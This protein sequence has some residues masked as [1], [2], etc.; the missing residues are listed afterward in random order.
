[1]ADDPAIDL[2]SVVW[3]ES[4]P[5]IARFGQ[6]AE[7]A[8]AA[9]EE[10]RRGRAVL[11]RNDASAAVSLAA[12]QAL[13]NVVGGPP[14][15]LDEH[16]NIG[17]ARA[18]NRVFEAASAPYVALLDPDGAPEPEML[19]AL[20]AV[21]DAN[22]DAAT[23][24]A[25]VLDF[26]V[27]AETR[28]AVVEEQ[29]T[30]GGATMYRRHAF[31]EIGGFDPLFPWYCQDMDFGYRARKNGWRCLRVPAAVFRHPVSR[32]A[33]VRR[34]WR[35]TESLLAWRHVHFSRA[36]TAKSWLAQL[37]LAL[38]TAQPPRW[39]TA[40]GVILGLM[41]YVRLIPACERRRR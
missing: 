16:R 2:V 20:V 18:V 8:W 38:R 41:S 11:L 39:A 37:P 30:P 33:S 25:Q 15:V 23:A 13:A 31:I 32:R 10:P 9:I 36:V 24:A 40:V 29:W 14:L 35:F 34:T 27:A 28:G 19:A 4:I 22:P 6:A 26:D 1:M 7:T 3:R 5:D 21:L 12:E 17:F